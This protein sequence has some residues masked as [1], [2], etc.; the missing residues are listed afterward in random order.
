MDTAR[1]NFLDKVRI[2]FFYVKNFYLASF[3]SRYLIQLKNDHAG[4]L[5]YIHTIT[6]LTFPLNQGRKISISLHSGLARMEK[7]FG[8]FRGHFS[9][10][11]LF[12]QLEPNK[13]RICYFLKNFV[14]TFVELFHVTFGTIEF[15]SQW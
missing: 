3:K 1:V 7:W 14:D 2:N 15:S 8:E 5:V 6:N 12:V 9:E 11:S 10:T 4:I 13:I